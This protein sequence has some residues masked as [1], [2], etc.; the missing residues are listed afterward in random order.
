LLLIDAVDNGAGEY[1]RGVVASATSGTT[2]NSKKAA[3]FPLLGYCESN[4]KL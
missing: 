3:T 2:A 4:K 1:R